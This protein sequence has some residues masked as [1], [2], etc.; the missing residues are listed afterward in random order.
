[1]KICFDA[2]VVIDIIGRPRSFPYSTFAYDVANVRRF[3]VVIASST[4]PTVDYILSKNGFSG[5]YPCSPIDAMLELFDVIDVAE[6]DCRSASNN[7]M[8]DY[9]DALIAE[10][11]LRNGV[12][13]IVTRDNRHFK[14]APIKALS[15]ED[16]VRIFKPDNYDY[17]VFDLDKEGAR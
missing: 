1:M 16:F 9:E 10:A 17:E 12:E 15:P 2:N 6:V 3:E 14:D 7:D 8:A 11:A 4:T 5:R 13:L